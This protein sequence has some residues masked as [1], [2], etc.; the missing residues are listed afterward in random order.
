MVS[1]HILYYT[2]TYRALTDMF[3]CA[4]KHFCVIHSPCD[5]L[6]IYRTRNWKYDDGYLS[7]D[8]S[9]TD[10]EDLDVD[11]ED[12]E[13]AAAS[14]SIKTRSTLIYIHSYSCTLHIQIIASFYFIKGSSVPT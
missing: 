13:A 9:T 1:I 5:C 12:L 14:V 3:E 2:D 11:Q 6:F 7:S 10:P 8:E 4:Y